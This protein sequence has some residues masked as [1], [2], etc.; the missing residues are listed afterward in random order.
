S[1]GSFTVTFTDGNGCSATSATTNVTV[2][3]NPTVTMAPLATVCVN[4]NAAPLTGG[5]PTGGTYTGTGVTA[6]SFDPGAAG[7][8]TH[9]ITYTFTDGNGCEGVATEDITVDGC[10]S[11]DENQLNGVSV[12]PNPTD[13][14]LF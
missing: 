6:G 3:T 5:S 9:T 7:T 11:I 10:A 12:Y 8:G 1:T 13:N 2:N 14:K 4:H